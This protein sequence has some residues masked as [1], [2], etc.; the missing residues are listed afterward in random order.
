MTAKKAKPKAKAHE[1]KPP[2][3]GS[4]LH[5]PALYVNR[6]LSLLEFQ[7]RVLE[8][9]QDPA[10][11]LLERVKF[12]SILGSNL[13]EFF[14]V[15]VA[16]LKNQLESGILETGPDGMSPA[17]QLEAIRARYMRLNRDAHACRRAI[18]DELRKLGIQIL[19]YGDMTET[20]C[21]TARRYFDETIYP[22]LT[23]LAFDPGR[24]FPH[25]SN[26]SLNLSILIR[27][28]D[29][30]EH[31][32]R[33]KVP[34]TLPQLVPLH[35][36]ANRRS[37]RPLTFVWIE[38][39]IQA[40]LGALFPGMAIVESHPFHVTRDAEMAIQEL[41][42]EDLLETVEEGVRQ[43][44]FGSVVRLKV[45]RQM[46]D[47]LLEILQTNLEL[48]DADV[49][50]IEGPLSLV[51]LRHVASLDRPELKDPAFTPAP[52]KGLAEDEDIFSLIRKGDTLLH[53]PFDSFVPVV[54]FLKAAA[55][56]P[57]VLAI[58]MT[59]YRVG[60][61]APVVEAL[62]DAN[63]RGKQVAVLVELKA[64][65]DEEPNIEW[66]K[67]LEKEGVHVVY[68]LIGMKVHCKAAMVVRREG[69][70]MRRYVHLSTGNYNA[71]TAHLY[72]D[73]GYFTTNEDFGADC[74]DLFNYLTGYSA[75]TDYR[76]LLVAPINLRK[77]LESMVEREIAH[78]KAGK[79][80][81]L[82][83]KMNALVDPRLIRLLYQ[84]SQA[85]VQ[86][87]L[88]CRGI[89]C[90]RPGIPGVSD[91]I[92]VTSIVGR[93]LEHSRIYY[94]RNRGEEEIYLGSADLMPR[95]I[96]RRVETLFPIER[97]ALVR[98][99]RDKIL[100]VYLNDNVKARRMKRDGNYERA[101][102]KE[103]EKPINSQAHLL[104]HR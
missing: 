64:R 63:A 57:N 101:P 42:A 97:P 13:D 67:A 85:G 9:A 80:A 60:R 77:R 37:G 39:V 21:E 23:P 45:P 50:R 18:F 15:R 56:D 32:A 55:R 93:F 69:A 84:A 44:R 70:V 28:P 20:Q 1:S 98:Q 25:I 103:G 36:P 94:F 24:P 7:G 78:A 62:L 79:E 75:K 82:I 61:N 95:N 65:F 58:K 51:R 26:L 29:G 35:K 43:R 38:Q 81:R 102:R 52:L 73:L 40:N 46:P 4:T 8:E 72:T 11:P 10:N 41:E 48:D 47:K 104:K 49:Y 19:E 6:E 22:I 59:L 99:I 54:D 87:D 33:V 2:S 96:N 27:Q 100:S 30:E 86:V 68:G 90:L 71:V 5:D 88:L 31:F 89:C 66:A 3:P 92:R 76:K 16:G 74:A 34:D 12:L 91:R 83:F 53:H 17:E 14:M